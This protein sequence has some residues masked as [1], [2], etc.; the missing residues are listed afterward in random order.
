MSSPPA[1][2]RL[3]LV[4]D[5]PPALARLRHLLAGCAGVVV[6]GEATDGAQ[7]L[8]AV[9]KLRP[10]ALLLDVQMPEVSGLDVAASLPGAAQGGPAIVF[11]TAFDHFALQALDAAA[12]DYLLKPVDPDRLAR[13]L[14]RLRD[15]A[16]V[17]RQ[18]PP[19]PQNLLVE[20][21]GRLH[22]LPLAHITW[23]TAADNYVEVH[24]SEGRQWLLRRPLAALLADLGAGFVRIHR[25]HAV[26]LTAVGGLRPA[27][28]GDGLVRLLDG[29]E[30]PCSRAHRATLMRALQWQV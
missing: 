26:A 4:D 5:E 9:Q 22:V 15:H 11:V 2:L 24:A 28:K 6:A 20:E 17:R 10:D 27:G 16:P 1:P 21:R 18:S 14:Q 29:H 3:L 19:P 25:S 12:V 23:L 8:L 30:L 7:A 13:A